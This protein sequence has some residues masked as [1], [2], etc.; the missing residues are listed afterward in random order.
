MSS[1]AP[2]LELSRSEGLGDQV[3][4]GD[5]AAPQDQGMVWKA[6]PARK[7]VT[8]GE[9]KIGRG[10]GDQHAGQLVEAMRKT[11]SMQQSISAPVLVTKHLL[12]L[13]TI[14]SPRLSSL[15]FIAARSQPALGSVKATA[16]VRA[17]DEKKGRR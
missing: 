12:P 8:M 14:S 5:G 9:V 1:V 7:E 16:P 2:A 10:E 4:D 17:A 3:V 13:S 6:L 15:T 11:P